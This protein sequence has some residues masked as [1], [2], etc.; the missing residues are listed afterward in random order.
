[1]FDSGWMTMAEYR[2]WEGDGGSDGVEVNDSEE[3]SEDEGEV[4]DGDISPLLSSS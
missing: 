3:E 2:L 4:G 1:M